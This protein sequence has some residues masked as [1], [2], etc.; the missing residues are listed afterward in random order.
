[1]AGIMELIGMAGFGA[2]LVFFG[3]LIVLWMQPQLQPLP[4]NTQQQA[5]RPTLSG[6]VL[7]GDP[8]DIWRLVR[9]PERAAAQCIRRAD[10]L[11]YTLVQYMNDGTGNI[12]ILFQLCPRRKIGEVASIAYP[13][14]FAEDN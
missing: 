7:F 4:V 8:F 10:R 6:D 9:V 1:M 2:L 12:Y 11:N 14:A 3:M 5:A 13:A